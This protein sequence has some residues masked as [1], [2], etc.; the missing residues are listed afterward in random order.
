MLQ[1]R[2]KRDE[3]RKGKKDVSKEKGKKMRQK[4]EISSFDA[5]FLSEEKCIKK[6]E[7]D[8]Y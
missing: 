8:A 5:F 2:K 3:P 7:K 6:E 4:K 1:Y